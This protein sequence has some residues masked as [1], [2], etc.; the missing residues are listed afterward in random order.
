MSK[1]LTTTGKLPQGLI[2]E[3][4]TYRH[5]EMREALL[6]DMIE[7]EVDAGGMEH[8][9]H[10]NAQLIAR[11]LVRVHDD[12]GAEYTGPFVVSMI[13]KRGD[14]IA[15][16]EAQLKLDELGNAEPSANETTGSP[17]S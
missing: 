9:L 7:A 2:I 17:F 12:T 6:A 5:F 16:R 15:L 3:G 14:F 8:S 10:Y 4:T 1:Q 13:K 11:Q